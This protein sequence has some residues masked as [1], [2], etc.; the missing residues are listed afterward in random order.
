MA[1]VATSS[2]AM[3]QTEGFTK[4][5]LFISG[6]VGFSSTTEPGTPDD[7]KINSF[8][9]SPRVGYFVTDKVAVGIGLG[10]GSNKN[11]DGTTE[12]KSTDL[13]IG[14]FGRYYF[15]PANKFSMMLQLAADYTTSKN[16]VDG[17]ETGKLNGFGVNFAPGLNY[18]I[19]NRLALETTVGVLGFNSSK[20]DVDG[21][22][23]TTNFNF[24]LGLNNITF[25]LVYKLK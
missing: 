14:A 22:D 9:F 7:T 11:D 23:A 18:F 20:P 21:A 2:V 3:A 24:N 17:N 4:G 8:N 1:I 13:S 25:G 16:E 12:V 19:S 10:F 15:T 6:N 5:S